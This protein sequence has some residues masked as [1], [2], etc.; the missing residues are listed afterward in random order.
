MA[1]VSGGAA[2]V[3]CTLTDAKGVSHEIPLSSFSLKTEVIEVTSYGD[4]WRRVIPGRME[5]TLTGRWDPPKNFMIWDSGGDK[6]W[7]DG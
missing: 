1:Q 2:H 4:E 7:T 6:Y 3:T 5:I